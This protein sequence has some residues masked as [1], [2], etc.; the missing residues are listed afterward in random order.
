MHVYAPE[1]EDLMNTPMPD[2]E[3]HQE[4]KVS[5]TVAVKLVVKKRAERAIL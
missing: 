2:F 3:K 5:L 1:E 4:R